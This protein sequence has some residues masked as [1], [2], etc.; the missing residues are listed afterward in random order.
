MNNEELNPW[1]MAK[2]KDSYSQRKSIVQQVLQRSTDVLR[3]IMAPV[4][5]QGGVTLSYVC[6]RCHRFPIE[7]HICRVSTEH[8]KRQCNWC[9]A[10]CGG[11]HKW[12]DPRRVLAVQDSTGSREAQVFRAAAPPPGACENSV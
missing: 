1:V 12:R 2:L 7:D 9:F 8:G 11:Q 5:V 10:A 6:P 3:R 4:E